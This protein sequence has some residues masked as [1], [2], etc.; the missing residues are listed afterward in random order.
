MGYHPNSD[1]MILKWSPPIQQPRG[2]LIPG[3]TLAIIGLSLWK[4]VTGVARPT[5]AFSQENL[6]PRIYMH[7]LDSNQPRKHFLVANK[8]SSNN[9]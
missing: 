3:L 4:V 2:L 6:Q 9:P 1:N 5:A 8:K 7:A